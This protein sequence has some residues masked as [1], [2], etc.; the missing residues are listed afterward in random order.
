MYFNNSMLIL[1]ALGI[2]LPPA[3]SI[4]EDVERLLEEL[5]G[6]HLRFSASPVFKKYIF[7]VFKSLRKTT[8][9]FYQIPSLLNIRKNPNGTFSYSG[10]HAEAVDYIAHL[11]NVT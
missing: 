3:L 6:G 7:E 8:K 11:L 5:S 2:A 1:I 9:L 10:V 4:P